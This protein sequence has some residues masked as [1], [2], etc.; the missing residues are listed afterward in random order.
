LSGAQ[1]APTA[2]LRRE[3]AAV[4]YVPNVLGA[5][6]PR[7]ML[8]V[9]PAIAPPAGSAGAERGA[10][11]SSSSSSTGGGGIG[12][13]SHGPLLGRLKEV[14]AATAA[15]A[16]ADNTANQ[17][18]QQ[19]EQQQQPQQQQQ[20]RPPPPA[21]L[22]VLRNKAPRWNEALGAYCLNFG[23]RVTVASVKNFQ[24]VADCSGDSG[25]AEDAI[26]MQFGKA[27]GDTFTCDFRWPLCALQ[28]FAL[29]L[30]SFDGKLACE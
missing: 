2:P 7:R 16:G 10:T 29:C 8:V 15:C 27:S 19:Q 13:A 21:D 18:Q 5:K 23:G 1:P 3:L 24:L 30:S 20:K 4:S 28:A 11:S 17:Q 6:G 14:A 9:A 25:G 12:I 22:V 26:V